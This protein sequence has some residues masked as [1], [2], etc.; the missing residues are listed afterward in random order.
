MRTKIA[1]VRASVFTS[2]VAGM[3]TLSPSSLI[4]IANPSKA[5]VIRFHCT[6]TPFI[7]EAWRSA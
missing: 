6:A 3:R 7:W 1:F 4:P 2:P 5:G